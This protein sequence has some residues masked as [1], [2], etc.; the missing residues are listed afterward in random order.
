MY[1]CILTLDVDRT[2]QSAMGNR[3][4]FSYVY[5]SPRTKGVGHGALI[6]FGYHLLRDEH[7]PRSETSSHDGAD[8]RVPTVVRE[9]SQSDVLLAGGNSPFSIDVECRLPWRSISILAHL[10]GTTTFPE[11]KLD[12]GRIVAI[13]VR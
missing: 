4:F 3:L 9:M 8:T 1:S 6:E 5:T 13:E 11:Y 7:F 2:I 10:P 12:V